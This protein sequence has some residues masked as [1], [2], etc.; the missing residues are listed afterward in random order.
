MVGEQVQEIVSRTRARVTRAKANLPGPGLGVLSR[1]P[2]MVDRFPMVAQMKAK[3]QGKV[4]T[5]GRGPMMQNA[6]PAPS[7]KGVKMPAPSGRRVK[8]V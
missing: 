8:T 2:S 6:T 7:R 4:A 1:S 5:L 3:V